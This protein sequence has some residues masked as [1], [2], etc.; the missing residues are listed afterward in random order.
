MNGEVVAN[1]TESDF[2]DAL[3]LIV[4]NAGNRVEVSPVAQPKAVLLGGQ[5]GAGKTSLHKIFME[6]FDKNAVIINGD[7]YRSLHPSYR[8]F[9]QK[10]GAESV[11]H[12]AAWAGRMTEA[13]IDA[14][15]DIGYNLIIEGTLRTAEVPLKTA[16]LLRERGYAVSLALMAVKPEIS[17]ISCQIRYEQMRIAGTVPRATDPAHHN[18]IVHDIVSNLGVL[19]TSG[20]FDEVFLFTR[21]QECLCPREGKDR[22]PSEVLNE[23]LFGPWLPGER[24]HHAKLQLMLNQLRSQAQKAEEEACRRYFARKGDVS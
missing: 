23:V 5:S 9:D 13:L 10:Y 4:D 8:E 20:L 15:S 22:K 16:T 6:R 17:L 24:K 12:T 21:A 11:N 19:E 18:K 7:S 14:L 1:Y 2:H 3:N